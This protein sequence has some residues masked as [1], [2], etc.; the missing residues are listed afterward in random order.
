MFLSTVISSAPSLRNSAV[1]CPALS[2]VMKTAEV[3]KPASTKTEITSQ[4][5]T[6]EPNLAWPGEDEEATEKLLSMTAATMVET[7]P[8]KARARENQKRGERPSGRETL[9]AWSVRRKELKVEAVVCF[10]RALLA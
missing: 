3:E 1:R 4:N 7:K 8:A 9:R 6:P 2:S 10:L 5:T